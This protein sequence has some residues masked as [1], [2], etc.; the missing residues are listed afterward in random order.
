MLHLSG[1]VI[2]IMAGVN[3]RHTPYKGRSPAI[4]DLL[5]SQISMVFDNAPSA[6]RT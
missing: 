2:Q 6:R 4:A 3:I 1:E 5:G